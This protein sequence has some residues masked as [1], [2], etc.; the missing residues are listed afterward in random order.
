MR[1]LYMSDPSM[2]NHF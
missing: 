1:H 2:G